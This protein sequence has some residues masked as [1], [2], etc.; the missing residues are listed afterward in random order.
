M[1][2]SR[3][4][5]AQQH[6]DN[7]RYNDNTTLTLPSNTGGKYYRSGYKINCTFFAANAAPMVFFGEGSQVPLM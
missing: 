2:Q 3:I 7:N 4:N 6:E 5:A 1:K